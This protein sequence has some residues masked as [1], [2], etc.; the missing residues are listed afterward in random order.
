MECP[1]CGSEDVDLDQDRVRVWQCQECGHAWNPDKAHP[2]VPVIPV[3]ETAEERETRL[4]ALAEKRRW[5]A[6]HVAEFQPRI[7][8]GSPVAIAVSYEGETAL[9][10]EKHRSDGV[11][12]YGPVPV[13]HPDD[14]VYFTVALNRALNSL[15]APLHTS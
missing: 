2:A 4:D 10:W 9:V 15:G 3:S 12:M 5:R 11:I 13:D 14:A 6:A 7:G 1:R 8:S